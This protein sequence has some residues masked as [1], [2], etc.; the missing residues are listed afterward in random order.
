MQGDERIWLRE[1]DMARIHEE[2]RCWMDVLAEQT[3]H[4]DFG[5]H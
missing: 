4:K 3:E 2:T 1:E 5:W